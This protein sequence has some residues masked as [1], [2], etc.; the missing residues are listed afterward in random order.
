[1]E[2]NGKNTT[3]GNAKRFFIPVFCSPLTDIRMCFSEAIIVL[4]AGPL[5]KR[6][7]TPSLPVLTVSMIQYLIANK[8]NPLR[9]T[10]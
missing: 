8:Q 7:C 10:V 4:L 3:G 5:L 2:F 9:S 6:L 1:V